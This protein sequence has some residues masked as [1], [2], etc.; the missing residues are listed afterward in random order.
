MLIDTFLAGDTTLEPLIQEYIV[1]AA[2]IQGI[3][4]P[5]GSLSTGAGLGEP[6]FYVN[7]T[8]FL[9]PWGRPQ[10]DGPP[11]RATALIAY[12]KYLLSTGKNSTVT[13]L[14]W[15]IIRNDLYYTA[16]YWNQT[17]FGL[18]EEIEGSSFF[19][20]S[21]SHRGL[22]EGSSLAAAIGQ[23]CENCDSQAP[24]I[25][26][27]LQSF[28]NGEY[29]RANINVNDGRAGKDINTV[30]GSIHTFDASASCD[31]NTFQPCSSRALANH[32][33][34]V[35]SFRSLYPIND[36]TPSG[37][38]VAIG[39]YAE[40]VFMGGNPWYLATFAAAEQMYDA[41]HQWST[42]GSIT[43]DDVSLAFFQNHVPGINQGTYTSSSSEYNAITTNL[44]AYADGFMSIAQKY[45]PESGA[46]SEQYSRDNGTQESAVDLT[47]S[48]AAF[49]TAR[50]RR[51]GQFPA[52]WLTPGSTN[53]PTQCSPSSAQGTYSSVTVTAFP[54][55]I[56]TPTPTSSACPSPTSIAVTFN[57]IVTTTYGEQI[58]I[59]GST[60]ELGNW[61]T[62]SSKRIALSADK[63]TN[64]DNLWYVKLTLPAGEAV[65]YKYYRVESD[66]SVN[67]ESDP[68][69]SYTVP[70]G[71][72]A[73]VTVNDTWR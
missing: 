68:N 61:S 41:L 31:D 32:K 37:Y 50:A 11:L 62:D 5:S 72:E 42:V 52:P 51:A 4:N 15:P 8:A 12:S 22:V 24:Q 46:L 47:W 9:G 44:K 59:T 53:V 66:G 1:S 60:A 17:G 43:V 67:W 65:E 56:T 16:Q 48:Y 28:W 18:W 49:L 39:R 58:Y 6:K 3:D 70:T 2:H 45:T 63:Y 10:R 35:D 26:C 69:R 40:D 13:D 27:F 14:V 25:L 73:S 34:V 30:L 23:S 55:G 38:A 54:T 36:G 64:F 20:L 29:V 19:T 71:C 21:V 57:E 7:E 33:V